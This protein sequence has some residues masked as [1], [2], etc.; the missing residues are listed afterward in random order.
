MQCLRPKRAIRTGLALLV[1]VLAAFVSGCASGEIPSAETPKGEVS[2]HVIDVGQGDAILV[3]ASGR[4]MMVDAGPREA[5][6]ALVAYLLVSGVEEIDL[7]MLT[8]PHSDHIGGV[9]AILDSFPVGQVVSNGATHTTR[10]FEACLEA[11]D[12]HSVPMTLGRAGDRFAL[13]EGVL[14]EVLHP[15]GTPGEHLNSDSLVIKLSV[16]RVVFL[17]MGDLPMEEEV[18]VARK[19]DVLKVLHHGSSDATG[20]LFLDVVRPEVAVISVGDNVYGHPHRETVECLAA[21]G[22]RTYRTDIVGTVVITTDGHSYEVK[23]LRGSWGVFL[24]VGAGVYH[25]LVAA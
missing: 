25:L 8:H 12:A 15:T 24:P 22:I 5:S 18:R 7:L 2:V 21:R 13:A 1:V 3:Q 17:L 16:G 14:G 9:P 6:D 19:A 10:T 23:T 20:A 4:V 11:I